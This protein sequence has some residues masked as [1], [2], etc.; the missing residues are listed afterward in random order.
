MHTAFIKIIPTAMYKEKCILFFIIKS[1]EKV[2]IK[3]EK[4]APIPV[5]IARSKSII[6]F[7]SK[8]FALS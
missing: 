1:L 2:K 7:R 4:K 3:D 8:V 5:N 6:K